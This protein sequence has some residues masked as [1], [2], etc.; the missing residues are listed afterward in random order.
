[1]D[2][3][4]H[5]FPR[6]SNQDG[7]AKGSPTSGSARQLTRNKGLAWV[8]AIT[9]GAGAAGAIGA[10]AIAVTLPQPTTAAS[11]NSAPAASTTGQARS[12]GGS[13][14]SAGSDDSEGSDENNSTSQA[15]AQAQPQAQSQLQPAAPPA[16]S[17]QP[18]AATSGAS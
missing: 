1:M 16:N 3:E 8:S 14:T 2:H 9:L 10:V 7:S 13:S 17:N 11:V 12:N 6:P 5:G 18:P 15:Q 4:Q